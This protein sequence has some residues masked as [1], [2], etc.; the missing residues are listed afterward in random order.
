MAGCGAREYKACT[1][2][3]IQAKLRWHERLLAPVGTCVVKAALRGG[4][5]QLE[6]WPR[7][8]LSAELVAMNLCARTPAV[9]HPTRRP[10]E[11]LGCMH[12]CCDATSPPW[13]GERCLGPGETS[14]L[15]RLTAHGTCM[16]SFLATDRRRPYPES[17]FT[18]RTRRQSGTRGNHCRM[19]PVKMVGKKRNTNA[20]SASPTHQ[21]PFKAA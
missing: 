17:R 6:W 15:E 18:Q 7:W 20:A 16:Y 12:R 1:K 8:A 4:R 5:F 14:S 13:L 19:L 21:H 10:R 11:A 2:S 9:Q 3:A